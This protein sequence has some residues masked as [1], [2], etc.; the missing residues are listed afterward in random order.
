MV[1]TLNGSLVLMK[2]STYLR[3]K[4]KP[5]A[6]NAASSSDCASSIPSQALI[7]ILVSQ[8]NV[9]SAFV[10]SASCIEDRIV[11]PKKYFS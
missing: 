6:S 4:K 2:D 9:P 11:S 10:E 7:N 1:E 8:H 5:F 3:V